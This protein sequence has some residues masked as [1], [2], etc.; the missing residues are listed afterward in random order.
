MDVSVNE[1]CPVALQ[2]HDIVE[3]FHGTR[4][5]DDVELE[6]ITEE[7][8][9]IQTQALQN[10][11]RQI[12]DLST[13]SSNHGMQRKAQAVLPLSEA[14]KKLFNETTTMRKQA[15]GSDPL[16][17]LA[18]MAAKYMRELFMEGFNAYF[19]ARQEGLRP[20]AGY[21][22]DGRRFLDDIGGVLTE[23]GIER[24]SLVRDR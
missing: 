12:A 17:A 2:L 9:V 15:D 20:T 13:R 3:R 6:V 8:R 7:R 10:A 19:A 24:E 14:Y 11:I 18:S 4:S 21:T 23:L 1:Y 5:I 16:A 22:T